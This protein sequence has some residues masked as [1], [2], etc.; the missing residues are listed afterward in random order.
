MSPRKPST[1]SGRPKPLRPRYL[2]L[3]VAGEIFP[4]PR[5]LEGA[6][7]QSLARRAAGVT[8]RVVRVEADRAIVEV[9]H[10]GSA[11][12]RAAWNGPLDL[13]GRPALRLA[14]RRTWG[15]LLKGK[16]WLRSGRPLRRGPPDA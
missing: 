8:V 10:G 3:E 15:T 5:L 4:P 6:L 13:P 11:E 16:Q 14:T 12:A 9:P 2:G 7:R 1:S